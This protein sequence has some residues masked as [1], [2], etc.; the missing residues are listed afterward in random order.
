MR[1]DSNEKKFAI[2]KS[3][4]YLL[5]ISLGEQYEDKRHG[6]SPGS[7]THRPF[8]GQSSAADRLSQRP[9]LGVVAKATVAEQRRRRVAMETER[10]RD[11]C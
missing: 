7:A 11:L 8:T 1:R 4:T 6:L 9:P 10:A 3:L 5:K 2:H